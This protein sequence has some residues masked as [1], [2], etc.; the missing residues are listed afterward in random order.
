MN[1]LP[2][3]IADKNVENKRMSNSASIQPVA[4]TSAAPDR[5]ATGSLDRRPLP[6][7]PPPHAVQ[8]GTLRNQLFVNLPPPTIKTAPTPPPSHLK[9]SVQSGKQMRKPIGT[10]SKRETDL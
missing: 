1:T 7:V 2:P 8:N 5:T 10:Q 6:P 3:Y 9:P 4:S